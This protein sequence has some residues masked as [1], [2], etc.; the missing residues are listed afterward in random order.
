MYVLMKMNGFGLFTSRLG[1][2]IVKSFLTDLMRASYGQDFP[3]VNFL[4]ILNKKLEQVHG[5]R[6]IAERM[7]L[8]LI[9]HNAKR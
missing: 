8:N 2:R 4:S 1:K 7:F 5:V 6:S 3:Q 9:S